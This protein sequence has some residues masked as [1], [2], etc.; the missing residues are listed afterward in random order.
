MLLAVVALW[1]RLTRAAGVIVVLL[2]PAVLYLLVVLALAASGRRE[3]LLVSL[4]CFA[5][6]LAAAWWH[7]S[8]SRSS[9]AAI[10]LVF[11]P[12]IAA[13]SGAIA[14]GF[15]AARRHPGALARTAGTMVILVAAVIPASEVVGAVQTKRLNV[16]RDLDQSRLDVAFQ[17]HRREIRALLARVSEHRADTL[18]ALLRA[19]RNDRAFVIAVLPEYGIDPAL[20][21]SMAQSPDL[22]IALQAV[23]NRGADSATLRRVYHSKIYPSYFYQAL[24]AHPHTPPDILRE[25]HQ[26]RPAPITGLD[27]WF[28]DNPFTP[29]DVIRDIA[30]STR[31]PEVARRLV[32]HPAVDCGMLERIATSVGEPLRDDPMLAHRLRVCS[33][34][35]PDSAVRGRAPE[36]S[37]A[38]R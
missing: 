3:G 32:R 36:H 38:R 12:F 1:T 24:V 35:A 14:L 34:A 7:I 22:G 25:I 30:R 11:L 2:A 10:G 6:T 33:G 23:R 21:D 26:M 18:T 28:A 9:T 16:R 15:G 19:N 31:D 4:A 29:S 17:R 27:I 13:I 20:L 8:A 37:N 5:A